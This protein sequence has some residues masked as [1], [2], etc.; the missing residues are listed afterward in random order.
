MN[1]VSAEAE[2]SALSLCRS[3][4]GRLVAPKPTWQGTDGAS[5]KRS[6]AALRDGSEG[7]AGRLCES[8]HTTIACTV[9]RCLDMAP[10]SLDQ[11]LRAVPISLAFAGSSGQK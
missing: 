7:L 2:P 4:A 3:D 9:S 10:G 11:R 8:H 5:R 1:I 6:F